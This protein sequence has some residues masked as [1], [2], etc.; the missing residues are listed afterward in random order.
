MVVTGQFHAP[1]SSPPGYGLN[2]RLGSP[3]ADLDVW[4]G[5][6]DDDDDAEGREG[7]GRLDR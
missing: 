7:A 6:N 3:R 5:E 2:G 4:T 1:A